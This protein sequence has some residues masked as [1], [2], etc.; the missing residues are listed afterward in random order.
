MSPR[1]RI[2]DQAPVDLSSLPAGLRDEVTHRLPPRDV[3]RL[4]AISKQ[5]RENYAEAAAEAT[6]NTLETVAARIH[7]AKGADLA[8]LDRLLNG[9]GGIAGLPPLLQAGPWRAAA[10]SL[11]D[12]VN[13]VADQPEPA[14]TGLFDHILQMARRLPEAERGI[15]LTHLAAVIQHLPQPD[16]HSRFA[17]LPTQAG[18]LPDADRLQLEEQLAK[19]IHTLAAGE[20]ASAFRQVLTAATTRPSQSRRTFI[21]ALRHQLE[22]LPAPDRL[23]AFLSL[24]DQSIAPG[25]QGAWEAIHLFPYLPRLPPDSKHQAFSALVRRLGLLREDD[26]DRLTGA[27]QLSRRIRDLPPASHEEAARQIAEVLRPLNASLRKHVLEAPAVPPAVKNAMR[28]AVAGDTA[29]TSGGAGT[30]ARP[31]AADPAHS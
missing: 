25:A 29:S 3:V 26:P 24:V 11:G 7:E 21:Q 30:S 27:V 20:R 14:R 8:T 5:A 15:P 2:P 22:H 12:L 13:Q 4:A 1:S 16:R 31:E 28:Q 10:E 9:P 19:T 17:E 23:A 6:L 18:P